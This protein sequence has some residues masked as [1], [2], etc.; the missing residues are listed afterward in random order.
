MSVSIAFRLSIG[1]SR[2]RRSSSFSTS[3]CLNRL[4]AVYRNLTLLGNARSLDPCGLCVSIAFRL[5]IGISRGRP[6]GKL[7]SFDPRSQSPFGCL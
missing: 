7:S 5:S 2:R 3:S 1:I 6:R 4:S